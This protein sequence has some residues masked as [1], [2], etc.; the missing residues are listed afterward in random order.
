[1]YS[2][3]HFTDTCLIRKRTDCF[4]PGERKPGGRGERK[5]G[6]GGK[7]SPGGLGGK[8]ARTFSLNATHLI[9]SLSMTLSVTVLTEFDCT[10]R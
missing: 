3:T 7:E 5:P 6:G 9:R 2:Q 4:V 1:M 8:K 10:A